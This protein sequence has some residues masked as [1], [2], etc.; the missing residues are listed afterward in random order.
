MNDQNP[1]P[2]PMPRT[3]IAVRLIEES[4]WLTLNQIADLSR[5][6]KSVISKHIKNIFETGELNPQRTGAEFA[7][8]QTEGGRSI[9]R[10]IELY[11]L[12][13]ILAVDNA[14]PHRRLRENHAGVYM[15]LI[16]S[17]RDVRTRPAALRLGADALPAS[18]VDLRSCGYSSFSVWLHRWCSAQVCRLPLRNRL[19]SP[20][21]A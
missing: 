4:V 18:V 2:A 11:R 19:V 21:I 14:K 12:E 8:V 1:Q 6:D 16:C 13:V 5:R 3:R 9:T 17:G 7:T 10:E 15:S 20:V